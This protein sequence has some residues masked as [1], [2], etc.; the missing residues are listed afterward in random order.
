MTTVIVSPTLTAQV[1]AGGAGLAC[2]VWA[3]REACCLFRPTD[4]QPRD[5]EPW[6]RRELDDGTAYFRLYSDEPETW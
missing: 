2:V 3:V 4:R 1:L 5:E 6:T